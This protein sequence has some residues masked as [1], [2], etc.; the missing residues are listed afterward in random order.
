MPYI[1]IEGEIPQGLDSYTNYQVY[2]C[3]DSAITAQLLP[4][5]KSNLN[6]ATATVYNREMRVLALCLEM[7]T[8]GF[9]VDQ[10]CLSSLLFDLQRDAARALAVLHRLCA[11]V[12]F[13]P[14]NPR[15]SVDVP[16]LFYRHL[17]LPEIWEFDRK[18]NQRKLSADIKALEK[19]QH[20]YPIA[21]PFVNAIISYR[22]SSKMASVFSRGLEPVTG[23]LRCNFSPSGTETG[24]LSSQQNP[25]Q[26]GTNGQNITDR[27]RQVVT[28]PPGFAILNFDLKTAES[29][30]VGY[31]SGDRA[32]IDACEGG[33]LHTGVC[34][35]V[36]PHMD[37]TGDRKVDK[38][39]AESP[40]YRHF[41][42][43]DQ[44]KRGG[45]GSNYY[46]QPS[47]IAGIINV[48]TKFVEDFQRNYFDA[49]PGIPEW[50]L[51]VIAQV[52][53]FGTITTQ[54][55]RERRFWGRPD[56]KATWREAIAFEPQ[57]LVGDIM[58]EGLIQVQQ[59]IKQQLPEAKTLLGR[60]KRLLEFNPR[61][62]DLR[63]Q[64]HD[65]GVFIVPLDGIAEI[66]REL[67]Q[68]LQYPIHFPGVGDMLIKNDVLIGKRWNKAHKG[69][70]HRFLKQGLRDY[71]PGDDVSWLREA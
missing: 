9:P 63:A 18:T 39:I 69:E 17:A 22:E 58:N 46:G 2:N 40:F 59:W 44:A 13:R 54:L 23:N 49:F 4:V 5:L 53:R 61:V 38:A 31:I 57:S 6:A 45:H 27:I 12:D 26:R 70:T 67:T 21:R 32:Y 48:P 37:W 24:R 66:A 3:L 71:E 20:N 10:M 1:E 15:S 43:R 34:K 11:A 30:A 65:A 41:S 25:Y 42:Y 29:V 51:N 60:G 62:P 14:I 8:K 56:D 50:H 28:A 36:W 33:D 68:R 64:I 16:D 7:S 35:L 52:Q 19:L 47:T 55:K